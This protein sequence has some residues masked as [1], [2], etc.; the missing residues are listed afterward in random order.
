[1]FVHNR[2]DNPQNHAELIEAKIRE[3]NEICLA[4]SYVTGSGVD[5]FLEAL[6]GKR[7]KL[8]CTFEMGI[9]QVTAIQRL[10]AAGISVKLYYSSTG[11]FHPKL[12]L[13]RKGQTWTALVG[14]ANFTRG[15]LFSNTE[16]GTFLEEESDVVEAKKFFDD[17]WNGKQVQQLSV[18]A[19]EKLHEIVVRKS[20]FKRKII[21]GI[22]RAST[23][24]KF[25]NLFEFAKSWIDVDK[26]VNYDLWPK[27]SYWRGWYIIPDQYEMNDQKIRMLQSI[28][29]FIKSDLKIGEN[30]Q[31]PEYKDLLEHYMKQDS[32][33]TGMTKHER[34]VRRAK[35][36]MIAFGW[37]EESGKRGQKILNITELGEKIRDANSLETIKELYTEYFWN[38]RH[39][40]IYL[41]RFVKAI[42]EQLE[43]IDRK[44]FRHFVF[45]ADSEE[46]LETIIQLIRD[47]RS[48]SDADKQRFNAE[49]ESY[50]KE[51]KGP[52]GKNVDGNYKKKIK[53]NLW[54]LAWCNH[55]TI[56]D[57]LTVR[58][59][60][61]EDEN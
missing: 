37:I 27:T 28:L 18:E 50:L 45:H 25:S 31:S 51:V 43:Y 39:H 46:D 48:L 55:F 61:N 4:V 47:Y 11:T 34:F 23:E 5:M 58:L 15:G 41:A 10:L 40:G 12:W 20:T 1:M 29:P 8:I 19:A 7:V 36:Y 30:D 2:S 21:S 56:D 22:E 35:N 14:S 53:F 54:A 26:K 9:T 42:L 52:T 17:L 57:K 13:F 59:A 32:G 33:E 6:R 16:A 60:E 38:R 49:V 44:E 24:D 3:A